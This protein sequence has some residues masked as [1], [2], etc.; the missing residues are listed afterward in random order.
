MLCHLELAGICHSSNVNSFFRIGWSVIAFFAPFLDVSCSP[1]A[2]AILVLTESK[3]A[4]FY[5]INVQLAYLCIAVGMNI[6][7]TILV[8]GRLLYIRNQVK[9]ALGKEH[10]EPY[11]SAAALV[12]ES[13]AL[14]SILG[15]IFIASFARH[16]DVSNLVFLSISHVQVCDYLHH[17]YGIGC[18]RLWGYSK[19]I[20]QL[21]IIL[22]VAKGT[23]YTE[24][25]TMRNDTTVSS[26]TLAERQLPTLM[27]GVSTKGKEDTANHEIKDV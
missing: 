8:V 20:A 26:L 4:V 17:Y 18:L 15:I 11:T 10:S 6:I 19:G 25:I 21:L 24:D 7:Y 16:S 13:A 12:V 9:N 3:G 23:A 14:Y 22:R 27:V 5:N 1:T 2:M